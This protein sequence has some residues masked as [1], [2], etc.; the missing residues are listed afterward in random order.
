MR[1]QL[2]IY[3]ASS[4]GFINSGTVSVQSYTAPLRQGTHS[5]TTTPARHGPASGVITK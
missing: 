2:H 4:A 3:A 1:M 5:S